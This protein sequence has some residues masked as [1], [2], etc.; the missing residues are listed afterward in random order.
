MRAT[1]T[2][3]SEKVAIEGLISC[4]DLTTCPFPPKCEPTKEAAELQTVM[5]S[6][7]FD[8]SLGGTSQHLFSSTPVN[9]YEPPYKD[10]VEGT[11]SPL[12]E[13]LTGTNWTWRAEITGNI[14]TGYIEDG[15]GGRCLIELRPA[16][17][18]PFDVT[19]IR[20]FANIRPDR[21]HPDDTAHNF[22][23]TAIVETNQG[24]ARIKMTGYSAC[25]TIGTCVPV[26]ERQ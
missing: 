4:L 16:S 9:L 7:L 3:R 13:T 11:L 14:L 22:L 15:A 17:N 24:T 21:K 26:T 2:G 18:I 5:N 19:K 6:L 20:G 25:V 12:T 8:F 1:I 10:I 23:I